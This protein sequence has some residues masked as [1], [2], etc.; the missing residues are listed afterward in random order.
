MKTD[1]PPERSGSPEREP[2]HHS[3][4]AD[5]GQAHG[6]LAGIE[7]VIAHFDARK[8][9][10]SRPEAECPAVFRFEPYAV[11]ASQTARHRELQV[12]TERCLFGQ[13]YGEEAKSPD[14]APSQD[15]RCR[16][17]AAVEY[18]EP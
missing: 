17:Q 8:D 15:G 16:Q 6:G 18:E 5:A 11:D 14:D 2:H 10:G 7:A 4:E 9:G 13:S 1:R 12:G 3:K